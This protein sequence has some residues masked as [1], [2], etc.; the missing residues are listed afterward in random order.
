M[1][2]TK[3][4]LTV[5]FPVKVDHRA[6]FQAAILHSTLD[7]IPLLHTYVS[8]PLDQV[9]K[10]GKDVEKLARE[11]GLESDSVQSATHGVTWLL[12]GVQPVKLNPKEYSAGLKSS[13]G[14][15]PLVDARLNPKE[16][17][18]GLKSIAG[19]KSLLDAA[20]LAASLF[21]PVSAPVSAP[22]FTPS[23]RPSL[24]S[25]TRS[26]S[27]NRKRGMLS[28]P[29][30]SSLSSTS[31]VEAPSRKKATPSSPT[32][33]S[34]RSLPPSSPGSVAPSVRSVRSVRSAV[35]NGN[36]STQPPWKPGGCAPT[37]TVPTPLPASTRK[38]PAPPPAPPLAPPPNLRAQS[39]RQPLSST[40]CH[41]FTRTAANAVGFDAAV[42]LAMLTAARLV[43]T[44]QELEATVF[45][46][47][48]LRPT[49]T[50]GSLVE[51]RSM[52]LLCTKVPTSTVDGAGPQY[53]LNLAG[54]EGSQTDGSVCVICNEKLSAVHQMFKRKAVLAANATPESKANNR[55]MGVESSS[56]KAA[57]LKHE[58]KMMVQT[59][60]RRR[61][62]REKAELFLEKEKSL[63]LNRDDPE[64]EK[65]HVNLQTMFNSTKAIQH[66]ENLPELTDYEMEEKE[67]ARLL[68]ENG[69]LAGTSMRRR[70]RYS[71]SAIKL[72]MSIVHKVTVHRRRSRRSRRRLQGS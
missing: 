65:L 7:D 68:F 47:P 17:I 48:S 21:P 66:I 14:R 27:S 45:T 10:F 18:D 3:N 72:A 52:P 69:K 62:A 40:P 2:L 64:A 16:Y 35:T 44:A 23:P 49:V 6:C 33:S 31:N 58:K 56:K 63:E 32:R 29:G 19:R 37:P 28:S 71:P 34:S 39:R 24:A 36:R 26:S 11:L 57:A 20:R 1:L 38:R 12:L 43:G 5:P 4:N 8:V 13:A 30:R 54:C 67:I 42:Q 60:A 55:W 25:P 51:G 59:E 22:V 9:P 41:G 46:S 50:V 61:K 70:V 15:K 53:R